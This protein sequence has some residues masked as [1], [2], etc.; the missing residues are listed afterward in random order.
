MTSIADLIKRRDELA[1]EQA[2]VE[3][4]IR[5]LQQAEKASV[6]ENIRS[7]MAQYG[8]T[9]ADLAPPARKTR[10]PGKAAEEGRVSK[11]VAAKYRH[12]ESGATWSGRG[13]QPKWLAAEVLKGARKEDFLVTPA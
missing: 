6:L 8:L 11:P 10:G 5:G 2:A 1:A 9:A 7:L 13:L 12:P 3:Q 4:Q